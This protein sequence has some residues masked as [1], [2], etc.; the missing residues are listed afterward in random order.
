VKF[1]EDEKIA[2]SMDGRGR[3]LDNVFIERIWR[4]LKYEEVYLNAYGSGHE[5]LEGI[6][7][8]FIK[9]NTRRPHQAL[10]NFYPK[11]IY[12]EEKILT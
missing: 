9:Y 11:E 3:A 8:Y 1:I 12:F 5:V 10:Q 4:S 7:R 2:I 6:G